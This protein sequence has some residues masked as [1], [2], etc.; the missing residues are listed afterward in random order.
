LRADFDPEEFWLP[1]EVHQAEGALASRLRITV[2]EAAEAL[3]DHADAAGITLVDA[4]L[5][6][7][8]AGG[9]TR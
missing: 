5:E 3:R 1:A 2:D 9:P 7:L 4:A 6:V 8:A